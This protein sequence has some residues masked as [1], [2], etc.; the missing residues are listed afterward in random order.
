M[1]L[2]DYS[3]WYSQHIGQNNQEKL[4]IFN[5]T[6]HHSKIFSKN[7]K[8]GYNQN[9]LSSGPFVSQARISDGEL[10]KSCLQQLKNKCV[11][12]KH[13]RLLVVGQKW[14]LKELKTLGGTSVVSLKWRQMISFPWLLMNWKMLLIFLN[15]YCLFKDS[16]LPWWLSGKKFACNT[17][18]AGS[19]A[20]GSGRSP[21]A[22]HGNHSSVLAWKIP[23]TEE[24]GRLQSKGFQRV[25]HDW[26]NWAQHSK[27]QYKVI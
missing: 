15:C 27:N 6:Y 20:S 18:D 23:W 8:W 3:S 2:L 10:I 26:S 25:R 13:L 14:F 1:I 24:P 11:K 17:G 5:E 21:G 9:K 4:E 16:G 19:P 22:E 7:K 12:W